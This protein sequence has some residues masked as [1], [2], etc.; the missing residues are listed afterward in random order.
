[1]KQYWLRR[2]NDLKPVLKQ[3]LKVQNVWCDTKTEASSQ[4]FVLWAGHLLE[5]K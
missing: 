3:M 5:N 1:V 2:V 4:S